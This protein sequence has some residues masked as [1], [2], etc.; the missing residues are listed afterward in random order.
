MTIIGGPVNETARIEALCKSLGRRLLVSEEVA[1]LV[2]HLD[3]VR[4]GQE[5]LR[6]T[7]H[8]T[9]L[10]TVEANASEPTRQTAV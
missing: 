7:R 6:G 9:T 5:T 4:V 8:A 1:R 3:L 2:P 10:F